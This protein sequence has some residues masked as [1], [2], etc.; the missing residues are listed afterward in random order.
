MCKVDYMYITQLR[1][2]KFKKGDIT[3][4][5][6]DVMGMCSRVIPIVKRVSDTF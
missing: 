3:L 1:L 4:N 2:Q 6:I 5:D